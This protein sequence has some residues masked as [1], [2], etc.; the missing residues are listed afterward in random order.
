MKY[1]YGKIFL[2]SETKELKYFVYD[3]AKD[4]YYTFVK[5]ICAQGYK[6]V[7]ITSNM[8]ITILKEYFFSRSFKINKVQFM[9]EDTELSNE[10]KQI[11][12]KVHEDR[13][14]IN[15]LLEKITFLSEEET[16]DIRKLDVSGRNTEKEAIGVSVQVNG[17]IGIATNTFDAELEILIKLIERC[18]K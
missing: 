10:T 6:Q 2:H 4:D 12:S 13:A 3:S 17:I 16:I 8:M 9:I 11:L 18:L 14:Y 7:I 1:I 5:S 15:V